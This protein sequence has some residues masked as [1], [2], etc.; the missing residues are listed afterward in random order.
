MVNAELTAKIMFLRTTPSKRDKI[1]HIYEIADDE[2]Q[3][4]F[5]SSYSS[6]IHGNQDLTTLQCGPRILCCI[7][8]RQRYP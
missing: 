5:Y 7:E 2:T 8:K 1:D 3:T 6:H 4:I